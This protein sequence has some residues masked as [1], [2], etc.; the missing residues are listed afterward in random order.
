M[1]VA[2]FAVVGLISAVLAITVKKTNPELAMQVSLAAG[3]LIFL[4]VAEYIVEAVDYIRE[5]AARYEQAYDG[6]VMVLKVVGIAYIC[7]FAIQILKDA[8]ENAIAARVE[9]GGKVLIMVI[10]LPL[11]SSFTELVLSLLGR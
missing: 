3:V 1:E 2:K 4:M 7:E 9:M 5:F 8:G 10:T 6:I 11:L